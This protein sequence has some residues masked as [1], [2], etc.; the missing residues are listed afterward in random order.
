MSYDYDLVHL[1]QILTLSVFNY[2]RGVIKIAW[3]EMSIGRVLFYY[4]YR[5]CNSGRVVD[6]AVGENVRFNILH[7][8]WDMSE[9][10]R[11]MSSENQ[12]KSIL[13]LGEGSKMMLYTETHVCRRCTGADAGARYKGRGGGTTFFVLGW[14]ISQEGGGGGPF[15]YK[16][17][18]EKI[19]RK[20]WRK[21][22][23]GYQNVK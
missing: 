19:W 18:D 15:M 9:I 23:W 7:A 17:G 22:G 5:T 10:W 14:F 12:A 11:C 6:G 2:W 16:V 4:S 8:P 3:T 1:S 21:E 20:W 13:V